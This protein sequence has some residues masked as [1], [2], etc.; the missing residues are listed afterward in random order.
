MS[1]S[2]FLYSGKYNTDFLYCL[3][4]AILSA[5][6]LRSVRLS[7]FDKDDYQ[8]FIYFGTF[9]FGGK[10][11]AFMINSDGEGT[12]RCQQGLNY[13]NCQFTCEMDNE[14]SFPIFRLNHPV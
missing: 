3:E 13:A 2:D 6:R 5:N 10:E 11:Y 12:Y 7:K 4:K 9:N 1:N 14:G 8:P